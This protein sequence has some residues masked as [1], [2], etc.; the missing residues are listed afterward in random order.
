MFTVIA[1]VRLVNSI[2][3]LYSVDRSVLIWF[4]RDGIEYDC[5]RYHWHVTR[6]VCL[7]WFVGFSLRSFLTPIDDYTHNKKYAS[8]KLTTAYEMNSPRNSFFFFFTTT[9]PPLITPAI[10]PDC[11]R[12][13]ISSSS[14]VGRFSFL[15]FFEHHDRE[16]C[17]HVDV[18]GCATACERA[19]V[20][21][22]GKM[23]RE[24][25]FCSFPCIGSWRVIWIFDK[26]F[27]RT[28]AGLVLAG[29]IIW[30]PRPTLCIQ[31]VDII[32]PLDIAP[33]PKQNQ[34]GPV[35]VT[36]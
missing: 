23:V 34:H 22:S 4:V 14:A 31:N 24:A 18:V 28:C 30:R 33:K 15:D 10:T 35:D 13:P 17:W 29:D 3:C 2:L 19:F 20:F 12:T 1:C 6:A 32:Q 27:A 9:T 26:R 16:H 7:P 36:C 25:A 11:T 5:I 8:S 21:D